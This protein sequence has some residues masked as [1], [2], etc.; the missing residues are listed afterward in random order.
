MNIIW[1]FDISTK[2]NIYTFCLN[3]EIHIAIININETQN[4]TPSG[5]ITTYKFILGLKSQRFVFFTYSNKF[6]SNINV[7]INSIDE[8]IAKGNRNR[9]K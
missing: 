3:F 4:R 1:L 8:N 6:E 5:I 9:H 2:K 7:A